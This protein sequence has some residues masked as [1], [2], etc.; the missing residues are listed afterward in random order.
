MS[1]K[2]YIIAYWKSIIDIKPLQVKTYVFTVIILGSY[3][4]PLSCQGQLNI[5]NF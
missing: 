4:V 5:D 3:Y 1:S 2:L